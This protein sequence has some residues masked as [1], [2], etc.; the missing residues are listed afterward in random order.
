M[1]G[2]EGWPDLEIRSLVAGWSIGCGAVARASWA[3][4]GRPTAHFNDA[5]SPTAFSSSSPHLSSNVANYL[6]QQHIRFI[7]GHRL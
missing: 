4:N 1:M 3:A 2:V 7:N 5:T 6:D